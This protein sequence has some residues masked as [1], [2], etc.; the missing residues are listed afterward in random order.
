MRVLAPR[1]LCALQDYDPFVA[2]QAALLLASN[3]EENTRRV[4][5]VINVAHTA[6]NLTAP[7]LAMSQLYWDVKEHILRME[8]S[9]LRALTFSVSYTH[10]HFCLLH[11]CRHL[12]CS[13]SL[14]SL[15]FYVLND[16]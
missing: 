15:V 16:S 2:A 1:L 14:T 8:Q 5:G 4:R 9:M 3:V 7:P 6:A 11:V 13:A 12:E 10:P